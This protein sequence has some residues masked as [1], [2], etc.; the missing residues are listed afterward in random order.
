MTLHEEIRD[1]LLSHGREMTTSDLAQEVNCRGNYHKKDGSA[2]M[3]SQVHARTKNYK[4]L[5][6]RQGPIVGLLEWNASVHH[7]PIPLQSARPTDSPTIRKRSRHE[8]VARAA[9]V[10][11]PHE[12]LEAMPP[13]A[14]EHARVLVLGTMPGAMSLGVQQYYAHPRNQFWPILFASFGAVPAQSYDERTAFLLNHRVALWDVLQACVRDGS[15]DTSII[16]GSERP[17][18]VADF[19]SAHPD[20]STIALNGQKACVLFHRL[21]AP[22]LSDLDRSWKAI[23]LPSTSHAHTMSFARKLAEWRK[24]LAAGV[25]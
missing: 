10:D 3:S 25:A 7:Q 20:I 16:R 1:I 11:S 21:I 12:V 5:F 18:G 22:T 6:T 23:Q 24:V 14:D 4:R 9:D 13:V 15:L 17:N 19:L 2:V 8:K